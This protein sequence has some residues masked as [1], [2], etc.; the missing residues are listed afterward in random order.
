M[1]RDRDFERDILIACGCIAV[2]MIGALAI[3]GPWA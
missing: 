3:W 1:T 2:A